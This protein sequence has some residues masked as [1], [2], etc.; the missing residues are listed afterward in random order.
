VSVHFAGAELAR[1]DA[2]TEVDALALSFFGDERPLRGV[3]G[4]CDWRLCGRLSRLL[5]AGRLSGLRGE[6]TMLPPPGGRLP[7]GRLFFFG[8]GESDYPAPFGEN[9]YRGAVR[10]MRQVLSRAGVTRYAVQPPGRAT[11]LIAPRRALELWLEVTNAD[12]I[13]ADVTIVESASGQKEMSE[14][15]RKATSPGEGRRAKTEA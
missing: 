1:L 11:G 12:G 9:E 13:D 7:F 3:A 2:L 8:L 14:A 4:L 6:V 10:E 15:L 5:R